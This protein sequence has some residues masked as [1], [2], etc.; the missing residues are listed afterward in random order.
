MSADYMIRDILLNN[1]F[2]KERKYVFKQQEKNIHKLP[3]RNLSKNT[4]LKII[5]IVKIDETLFVAIPKEDK[6]LLLK[7]GD[8]YNGFVIKKVFRN[9]I[10]IEDSL[11]RVEREIII[12]KNL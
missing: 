2:S 11:R 8:R 12:N 1:P 6:I 5:G 7:E 10:V 3:V 4:E 9:K